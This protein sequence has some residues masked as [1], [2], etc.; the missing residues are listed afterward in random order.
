MDCSSLTL[1]IHLLKA[2]SLMKNIIPHILLLQSLVWFGGTASRTS[3]LVAGPAHDERASV[4]DHASKMLDSQDV[5]E[6]AWGAY[7]AGQNGL[8][9]LE[10]E[11]ESILEEAGTSG[12]DE[13]LVRSILDAD[14]QMRAALPAKILA[15]ICDRYPNETTI[16]LAQSPQDY[17]DLTLSLFQKQGV[18]ARWLALGN[19][20]LQ[21]KA[22]GFPLVLMQGMKQIPIV[23][24]VHDPG[25]GGG[26]I[27]GSWGQGV[28]NFTVPVDFPPVA[29]YDL[30]DRPDSDA[31]AI[32]AGPH[33][34]YAV[35]TVVHPGESIRVLNGGGSIADYWEINAYRLE[36]LLSFLALPGDDIRFNKYFSLDWRGPG[37][38]AEEVRS[39][40]SRTLQK[41]DQIL[42][43]LQDRN[44]VAPTEIKTLE[45][46]ISLRITDFRQDK[47]VAVPNIH[48]E[49]VTV[50]EQ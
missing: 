34:I 18:S 2:T 39:L 23:I 25:D 38:F 32:A 15:S 12:H 48:M 9:E 43:L 47:T 40:C 4:L 17:T 11:L 28:G 45:G 50:E 33:T 37:E 13:S 21:T 30:S 49:R 22:P 46:E 8:S 19:L 7:L 42:T 3:S 26:G 36:Y 35:K 10:P 31:T 16:L 1:A 44:L 29:V 5:R 20:L 6:R 41:Y 24:S 14:I 27:G